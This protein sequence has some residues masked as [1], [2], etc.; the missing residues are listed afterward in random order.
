MAPLTPHEL[1]HSAATLNLAAGVP[2]SLVAYLL[3]HASVNIT[4]R[5]YLHP[6]EQVQAA[7][8]A[9]FGAYIEGEQPPEPPK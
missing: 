1:R 8:A 6:L 9:Q 7:A 4:H 2:L 3:G 5:F